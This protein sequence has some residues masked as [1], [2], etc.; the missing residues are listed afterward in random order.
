MNDMVNEKLR[1]IINI[2]FDSQNGSPYWLEKERLL[3]LNVRKEI[4][5]IKDLP[6]LGVM[7]EQALMHRPIEDFI[8]RL[9]RDCKDYIIAETAGTSGHP[10]TAIHRNDEFYAAFVEPFIEATKICNFPTEGHW[11][12]IGPTGPHIIGQAAK[13]CAL[14]LGCGD[15]FRVDFDPRWA[16]TLV[17]GSFAAMRYLEHIERQS[18]AILEVQ[19]ISVIFSTPAVLESLSEK[20]SSEQKQNISGLHLGGMA[21]S[22]EFMKKMS[23]EFP[24]AV[25]LSGFGNTLFGMMPHLNYNSE[26]GFDYFP[27]GNRLIVQIFENSEDKFKLNPVK[28]VDYNQ[29]GRIVM[30]RLDEFQFIA[31]MVERD[32]AIRIE[33]SQNHK[34]KGFIMDGIRDPKP[35]VSEI[36]KFSVGLY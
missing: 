3:G 1:H 7:D 2:H 15:I 24:E 12:F 33:P 10:K 6:V 27:L 30:S 22:N 5:T 16:K 20:L 19:N 25:I 35:V 31:N 4:Q 28:L 21:A 26:T 9:F 32:T 36:P 34:S 17:P 13:A 18:L 23:K 11:L 14:A 29:R 8:P